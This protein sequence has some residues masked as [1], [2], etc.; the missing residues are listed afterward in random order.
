MEHRH[1]QQH[2]LAARQ[3]QDVLHTGRQRVQ[4]RRAMAIQHP[5]GIASRP[6]GVAQRRS[7]VLVEDRPHKVGILA[8]QK[9]LVRQKARQLLSRGGRRS[10][11]GQ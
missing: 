2:T 10:L 9:R 7:G 5:F 11:V 8:R 3:G 4:Q 1:N 6:R